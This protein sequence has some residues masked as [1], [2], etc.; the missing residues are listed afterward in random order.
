MVVVGVVME[1]VVVGIVMVLVVPMMKRV[2]KRVMV[3]NSTDGDVD[4]DGK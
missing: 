3:V 1:L 2:M 4:D